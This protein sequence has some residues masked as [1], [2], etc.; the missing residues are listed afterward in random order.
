MRLA[1]LL[2]TLAPAAA[3]AGELPI[4]DRVVELVRQNHDPASLR[5]P[6]LVIGA[7]QAWARADERLE[8]H[9]DP[10]D[11]PTSLLLRTGGGTVRLDLAGVR[12]FAQAASTVRASAGE[13][14]RS[15]S[16]R[17]RRSPI[18]CPVVSVQAQNMPPTPPDSSGT[19]L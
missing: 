18:T 9:A 19:G 11:R 5:G 2:V 1:A 13:T 6:E 17:S 10:P 8:V 15:R 4:F 12:S 7:F 14:A 3:G 16:V